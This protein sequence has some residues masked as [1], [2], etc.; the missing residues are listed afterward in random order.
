[1]VTTS[2]SEL[3]H[4]TASC[5]TSQRLDS[6]KF[7]D[8]SSSADIIASRRLPRQ[9]PLDAAQQALRINRLRLVGICALR[10]RERRAAR[11]VAGRDED[12]RD[13][14]LRRVAHATHQVRAVRR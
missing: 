1:M 7:Y 2:T 5:H 14:K 12:R 11:A 3:T 4:P 9:K 10:E 6:E 13:Q 8:A